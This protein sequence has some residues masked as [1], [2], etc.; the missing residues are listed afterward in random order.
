MIASCIGHSVLG[1]HQLGRLTFCL[2]ITAIPLLKPQAAAATPSTLFIVGSDSASASNQFLVGAIQYNPGLAPGVT[3]T[4]TIIEPNADFIPPS[5]VTIVDSTYVYSLADIKV[6]AP[7]K[8]LQD[9]GAGQIEIHTV[10]VTS[11]FADPYE[12]ST[13]TIGNGQFK[14][15][16]PLVTPEPTLGSLISDIVANQNNASVI[17][18]GNPYSLNALDTSFKSVFVDGIDGVSGSAPALSYIH[19]EVT[20]DLSEP[21]TIDHMPTQISANFAPNY[22]ITLTTAAAIAGYSHFD[23]VQT[24]TTTPVVTQ[25]AIPLID[26]VNLTGHVISFPTPDPPPGGWIYQGYLGFSPYY[27]D[28]NS[29]SLNSA[30]NLDRHIFADRLLTFDDHPADECL[31]GGQPPFGFS[32]ETWCGGVVPDG[33]KLQFTTQLVG[34]DL[35]TN[36]PIKLF[37]WTWTDSFNGTSGG[38]TKLSNPDPVDLDSG[39]GGITVIAINGIPLVASVP[40]PATIAVMTSGLGIAMVMRRRR[41]TPQP[42]RA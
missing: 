35:E 8:S 18:A 4:T 11:A 7:F 39:S 29:A 42:Q 30:Y 28:P 13:A 20:I 5:P 16:L 10:S 25:N 23:W 32:Q 14:I 34:I 36:L 27:H 12:T 22:G 21:N 41:R 17:F 37:E 40:E 3:S 1:R 33:T 31:P 9:F 38:V 6:Q 2:A 19:G 15:T 24:E 26:R